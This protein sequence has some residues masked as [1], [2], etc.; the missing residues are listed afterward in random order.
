M[1]LRHDCTNMQVA[2]R[3]SLLHWKSRQRV[4]LDCIACLGLF[5]HDCCYSRIGLAGFSVALKRLLKESALMCE[6]CHCV[7]A[8]GSDGA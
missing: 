1:H 8:Q 3:S 5:V 7:H 4:K 2:L 6:L